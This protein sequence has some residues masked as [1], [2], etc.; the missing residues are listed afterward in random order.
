MFELLEELISVKLTICFLFV[1]S[2]TLEYSLNCLLVMLVVRSTGSLIQTLSVE[3]LC[4]SLSMVIVST[5]RDVVLI[6]SG[7]WELLLL[8][9]SVV[10]G[11]EGCWVGSEISCCIEERKL[12]TLEFELFLCSVVMVAICAMLEVL[13]FS[14]TVALLPLAT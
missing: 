11:L 1:S 14:D 3:F 6:S 9:V 5:V 2:V 4:D 12:V 10:F 8:L 7:S 13:A